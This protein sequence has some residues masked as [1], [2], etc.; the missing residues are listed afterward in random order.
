MNNKQFKKQ[1][2]AYNAQLLHESKSVY[3][4][5]NMR[6]N[7]E[8]S[9]DILWHYLRKCAD[10]I[11]VVYIHKGIKLDRI[12]FGKQD[13]RGNYSITVFYKGEIVTQRIF[14]YTKQ[15]DFVNFLGGIGFMAEGTMI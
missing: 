7:K 5:T 4:G 1:Y 14:G 12:E 6:G 8:T 2:D 10:T 11:A 15:K 13:P 3:V 9:T